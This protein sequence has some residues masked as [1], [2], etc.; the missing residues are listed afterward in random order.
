MKSENSTSTPGTDSSQPKLEP[1]EV[2]IRELPTASSTSYDT[3]EL[4][5]TGKTVSVHSLPSQGLRIPCD[6]EKE[7][8]RLA[9]LRSNRPR[10]TGSSFASS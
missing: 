4:S 9:N 5:N 3:S 7:R 1:G 6:V 8:K 10:E 2:R